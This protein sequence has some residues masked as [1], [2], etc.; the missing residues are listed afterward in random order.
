MSHHIVIPDTQVKPEIDFSY[1]SQI[2]EYIA[3]RRPDTIVHLG[4]FADMPSLSTYDIGKKEFEG[5]SYKADIES[6]KE[7]M[8]ILM[9]PIY[10]EIDRRIKGKRKSWKPRFVMTLG[11]HEC[12]DKHTEV[13]TN[14]G[15]KFFKDIDD[16]DLV[17]TMNKN[18]VGEWQAPTEKIVKHYTGKLL[19]HSSRTIDLCVTP[20]HRILWTNNN[21]NTIHEGFAKDA[22]NN[23]DVF[24]SAN[25]GANSGNGIELTDDQIMFNAIALTDSY[26]GKYDSLT[27]YQSGDKA[28]KI[29]ECIENANISFTEKKR[30]RNITH[31][32]GKELKQKPKIS[33][34]FYMKRPSWCVDQNKRIPKEFWNMNEKQFDIFLNTMIFCDGTIPTKSKKSFVFYG[35]KEICEDLQSLCLTK[36][37]RS[38]ITEYRNNQYRINI[39]KTNLCRVKDFLTHEIYYDDYV[40]C[41]SVPNENLMIRRNGKPVIQGNCRIN[42]AIN[43]DRKLDGLISI[44]DLEYEKFGWEVIPFLQPI[45]IDGICYA[46]YMVS[47]VMGNPIGRA[48]TLLNKMHMSTIVGHQQ[49]RD[50]AYGKRADGKAITCI[51]SGS[52]YIH[53]ENYLNHQ[54]NN[55]WRGFIEL[56]NVDDGEFDERFI[57]LKNFIK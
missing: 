10:R 9:E 43:L 50:I 24:V 22:P 37:H 2:G 19:Y 35:K 49:G 6:S 23:C 36:G 56:E 32:C 33:Y 28:D 41:L 16:S 11:N 15:W 21:S 39:V 20:N 30:E 38:T 42:R 54:T 44:D 3:D 7:A 8:Q 55:H 31:I 14:N 1:L 17:F 40:Y 5:R 25:S 12:Y 18:M 46:H 51:I 52:C 45:S 13:L 29:R 27:F 53:N 47:G 26:H 57:N 48:I 34:E 4:D